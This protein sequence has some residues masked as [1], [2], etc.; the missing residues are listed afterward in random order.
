MS[1]NGSEGTQNQI[2]SPRKL[3]RVEEEMKQIFGS[4]PS[5]SQSDHS[6]GDAVEDDGKTTP[7]VVEAGG[8]SKDGGETDGDGGCSDTETGVVGGAADGGDE[9]AVDGDGDGSESEP[10]DGYGVCRRTLTGGGGGSG[11]IGESPADG[12][13]AGGETA[14]V[15]VGGGGVAIIETAPA[16]IVGGSGVTGIETAPAIVSGSGVADIETAPVT[17][18]GGGV[19]GNETAPLIVGGGVTGIVTA[20]LIVGSGGGVVGTETAP[21]IVA[22]SQNALRI[23]GGG[24]VGTETAPA[25]VAGTQNALRIVGGG[26]LAGI[27]I[28]LTIVGDG[29]AGIET[30]PTIVGGGVAGIETA[31]T[32]I[33]GGGFAGIETAPAII[34]GGGG[35]AGIE[36]A[37]SIVGGSGGGSYGGSSFITPGSVVGGRNSSDGF[38]FDLNVEHNIDS[39]DETDDQKQVLNQAAVEI[40]DGREVSRDAAP[41]GVAADGGWVVPD[42]DGVDEEEGEPSRKRIRYSHDGGE[43]PVEQQ[44]YDLRLFGIGISSHKKEPYGPN[45]SAGSSFNTATP[46]GCLVAGCSGGGFPPINPP[47]DEIGLRLFGMDISSTERELMA[48]LFRANNGGDDG[49]GGLV[50]DVT[51]TKCYI[52]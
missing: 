22:G 49:G 20:P 10:V 8:G 36:T 18:G 42:G 12:G 9:T 24:V 3:D 1:E 21:A 32:M 44:N 41:I 50:L 26:G 4:S 28:A 46:G 19:A 16:P 5:Q 47:S 31:R 48:A 7:T 51:W 35:F 15:V 27:E 17:V 13:V 40:S 2:Q 23:V 45:D 52:T 34:G 25:I 11:S 14:S 43:P 37:P 39:D 33:G 38:A 6:G 29:F 30:A